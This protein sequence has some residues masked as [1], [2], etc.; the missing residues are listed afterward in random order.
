MQPGNGSVKKIEAG[1]TDRINDSTSLALGDTAQDPNPADPRVVEVPMVDY[2]GVH[3]KS[4]LA[5]ITG[6]AEVWLVGSRKGRL[7]VIFIQAVSPGN[8]RG[9]SCQNFGSYMPVLS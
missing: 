4:T 1:V 2:T 3:G 6:F 8:M 9:G 7:Q 5:P